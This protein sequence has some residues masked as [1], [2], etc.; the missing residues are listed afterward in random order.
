M[1]LSEV[2]MKKI[3]LA[4]KIFLGFVLGIIIGLI[5]KEQASVIKPIGDIFLRIIK[6]IVVP[7]IFFSITL[8]VAGMG[9]I[10]KVRRI[11]TKTLL[12]YI[13]TTLIAASFGLFIAHLIKP[14]SGFNMDIISSGDVA[15]STAEMPT[16]GETLVNM[17][18]DNPVQA[19]AET[20]LLQIIVFS[21]FLG[22][23]IIMIGEKGKP[24]LEFIEAS[25]EIMQKMTAIVMEFSPIGVLALM[26]DTIGKYGLSIFGPFGKFILTDYL[27]LIIMILIMY[28]IMV[29]FIAKIPLNVFYKHIVKIWAVTLS[30]ASSSGS[31]PVTLE[32]T[33]EDFKVDNDLA[34]FTL[35]LGA[36]VNM[37]GA[38]LY[39]GALVVF[40]SQIYGIDLTIGQ[41]ITV[42]LTTTLL[43]VGSAGIPGSGIVMSIILL[44]T[45]GLPMEIMGIIAGIYRIIDMGHTTLNVTGDVVSTLCI[46]RSENMFI[47]EPA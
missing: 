24:V 39:Y 1:K 30:T 45:M 3:S 44:K 38:G 15:Q 21:L 32:K 29:K 17:F 47:E 27:G 2:K 43:S 34:S 31:L 11:G 35:P 25:S 46:A 36:T 6:M 16:I 14:G 33:T 23:S 20:E 28:N 5:F 40:V 19:M 22:I 37:N 42:I 10:S 26:A 41:Q 9:D 13:V 12:Y 7:L 4:T 8:G 18:P